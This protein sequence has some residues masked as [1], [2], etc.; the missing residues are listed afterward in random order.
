MDG[1]LAD[2]K[3]MGFWVCRITDWIGEGDVRVVQW[4]KK[5]FLIN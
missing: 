2:W 5:Q 3:K 1:R 4:W